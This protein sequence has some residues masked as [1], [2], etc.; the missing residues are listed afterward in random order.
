MVIDKEDRKKIFFHDFKEGIFIEKESKDSGSYIIIL[1]VKKDISLN[2]GN[3]GTLRF[4]RGYYLYVGS[5]KTNLTKRIERHKRKRKR[6]FWHID[7]LRDKAE[8]CT[9][10]PMRASTHLECRIAETLSGITD[11]SVSGFGSSDCSC[12]T[13]LFG[14]HKDPITSA[15]FIEALLYYR[16]DRLEGEF[17]SFSIL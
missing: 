10:L 5:A 9:A 7:Y 1:Y 17:P 11:W 3:I 15:T 16:I 13:H 6:L 14:M 8:F 4:N 2:I 12:K